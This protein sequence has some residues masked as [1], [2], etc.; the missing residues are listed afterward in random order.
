MVCDQSN[1]ASSLRASDFSLVSWLAVNGES[2]PELAAAVMYEA[3]GRVNDAET[4]GQIGLR[5]VFMRLVGTA[6]VK[7]Y[8]S[9]AALAFMR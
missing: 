9:S 3:L 8:T 7:R 4:T 5:S 2:L 6:D 1:F